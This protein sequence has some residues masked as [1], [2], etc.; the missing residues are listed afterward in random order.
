M[1]EALRTRIASL[2]CIVVDGGTDP[3]IG[4]VICHGY[5]A[6]YDDL[7]GL[8]NEWLSLLG[9]QGRQVPFC[10]S[11]CAKLTCRNWVCRRDVPGGR[12]IWRVLAEAVQ[13]SDFEELHEHEPPGVTE[14]RLSTL[15]HDYI[16]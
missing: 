11:G 5:G 12:S 16:W 7:A 3:S 15:R 4:V 14:A 10:F 2:D 9:D 8:S 6:S 1:P 13:A